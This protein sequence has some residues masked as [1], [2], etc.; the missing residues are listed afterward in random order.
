MPLKMGGDGGV[1]KGSSGKICWVPMVYLATNCHT[2]MCT[3]VH[4]NNTAA[5]SCLVFLLTST[6]FSTTSVSTSHINFTWMVWWFVFPLLH[7]FT[8]SNFVGVAFTDSGLEIM[9]SQWAGICEAYDMYFFHLLFSSF[10]LTSWQL[11]DTFYIILNLPSCL[12]LNHCISGY[13]LI[14][15]YSCYAVLYLLYYYTFLY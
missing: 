13:L 12:P 14:N 5:W 10:V 8:D 9:G 6:H 4:L 7:S 3:L 2:A 11:L 1:N 15:F